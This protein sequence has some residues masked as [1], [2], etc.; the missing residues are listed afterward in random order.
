[1]NSKSKVVFLAAF[2]VALLAVP[3]SSYAAQQE[4][5][6]QAHAKKAPAYNPDKGIPIGRVY[7][8]ESSGPIT[9]SAA[10]NFQNHFTIDY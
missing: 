4:Q 3:I 10:E 6:K 7:L 9:T 8:L 5:A 2:A 1:M